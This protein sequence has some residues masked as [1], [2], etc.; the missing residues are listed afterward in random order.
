MNKKTKIIFGISSI[1]SIPVI[2]LSLSSKCTT[3]FVKKLST[4]QALEMINKNKTNKDFVLLDVRTEG[5]INE[6]YIEGMSNVNFKDPNFK[7]EINKFDKNKTYLVYCRTQNRS[8]AA[9]KIM[10]ELGFK[11]IYWMNGGITQW[12]RE[13]KPVINVN[14]HKK[15]LLINSEKNIFKESED[16]TFSVKLENFNQEHTVF[17]FELKNEDNILIKKEK[18]TK[19]INFV[20]SIKSIFG[21][22]LVLEKEKQY[23][24]WI[25]CENV[26]NVNEASFNF[27][28]SK[29]NI[30][31]KDLN[32]Y[33]FK[34]AYSHIAKY[35][36][37]E[38]NEN[39][40]N[41]NFGHN[42]YQYKASNMEKITKTIDDL[43]DHTKKSIILF[44]SP[45]CLSCMEYLVWLD[46][47]N[48]DKFNFVKILTSVNDNVDQYIDSAKET[49]KEKNI[50]SQLPDSL[51]DN[52]DLI[53]KT[54]LSFNTTPKI[55]L[56]D[57]FGKI[58]NAI[59][60]LDKNNFNNEFIDVVDKTFDEK[61]VEK[62][63][64]NTNPNP[65]PENPIPDNPKDDKGKF[66]NEY[67]TFEQR[68][69]TEKNEIKYLKE[70]DWE[71]TSKIYGL[72][73]SEFRVW[74]NDNTDIKL[75]DVLKKNGK[76]T[77][78][79][80]GATYCGE[81]A[82]AL[83]Y[84]TK[85]KLENANFIELLRGSNDWENFIEQNSSKSKIDKEIFRPSTD[86]KKITENYGFIPQGFVLDKE[87]N[88]TYFFGS[89]YFLAQTLVNVVN[90][91][92]STNDE[93]KTKKQES[94]SSKDFYNGEYEKIKQ[95]YPNDENNINETQHKNW[96]TIENN[97]YVRKSQIGDKE[98]E[99]NELKDIYNDYVNSLNKNILNLYKYNFNARYLSEAIFKWAQEDW[100]DHAYIHF[101]G[102]PI[103]PF[104]ET[105]HFDDSTKKINDQFIKLAYLSKNWRQGIYSVDKEIITNNEIK[106]KFINF[107][108]DALDL[109]NDNMDEQEKI[110]V[111]M[112]YV[113]DRYTYYDD[114]WKVNLSETI[115]RDFYGVCQ[116]Y[117]WMTALL[118]NIIGIPAFPKLSDNYSHQF[119]WV[120]TKTKNDEEPKWYYV[121]SLH[122]DTENDNT[123]RYPSGIL[124]NVNFKNGY[125]LKINTDILSIPNKNID[126]MH[127][128]GYQIFKNKLPIDYLFTEKQMA[129]N[130]Y[131]EYTILNDSKKSKNGLILGKQSRFF[132]YK[133]NWYTFAAYIEN[134]SDDS[135]KL[136]LFKSNFHAGSKEFVLVADKNKIENDEIGKLFNT[137]FF[138]I[139]G[140]ES[141]PKV[142]MVG[143]VAFVY[144]YIKN[145]KNHELFALNLKT[146]QK[147]D[148]QNY[149][150]N[151]ISDKNEEYD[152]FSYDHSLY[153]KKMFV[154]KNEAI[155]NNNIFKI[156][157]NQFTE[158]KE[159]IKN[160]NTKFGIYKKILAY[161]FE[162]GTYMYKDL[163]I[164]QE[165]NGI[166]FKSLILR[167]QFNE[168]I[169]EFMDLYNDNNS[170][171]N[172]LISKEKEIKQSLKEITKK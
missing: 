28:I 49:F 141:V 87:Q 162:A 97:S 55:L 111:I 151:T 153:I 164:I 52:K 35:P 17:S 113:A 2:A 85:N 121:D 150:N 15:N 30:N 82:N 29:N 90:N 64:D 93:S 123:H 117:S 155:L 166:V 100:I 144:K 142:F 119:V 54:K 161:R 125:L 67:R 136:G 116:Q 148:L 36:S 95:F 104:T 62:T 16:I 83:K 46:K 60:G 71:I 129:K 124:K 145:T 4:D 107:V 38:I 12:L 63:N 159:L 157:L 98:A 86:W 134:N 120:K 128:P 22:D 32:Y 156:D 160:K 8:Q 70:K 139:N 152:I 20:S 10:K 140:Y 158:L 138:N 25:K 42:M 43:V 102:F 37:N 130:S 96:S 81:C 61:I 14:S 154:K 33:K 50:E 58:V 106:T 76:P 1:T 108:K 147:I 40:I 172:Q 94:Q 101:G 24:L 135:K 56:V 103:V 169:K 21:N 18:I 115:R 163:N 105:Y 39:F 110:Y 9:A 74:K 118:L 149:F 53:W 19:K 137:S 132:K 13:N 44:A 11:Y 68:K 112:Q 99:I 57:E 84:L 131:L 143:N 3:D 31:L 23:S 69:R 47:L 126:A 170:T 48:L 77:I 27:K 114:A 88:V 7:N 92:I 79:F 75:K 165:E 41:K 66:E 45:T 5:E 72:N 91:T 171:L 146:G 168:K 26:S 127:Y 73:V 89:N 109:I 51:L 59:D 6:Q 80:Y 34:G 167:K 133:S 65:K 122:F 78:V